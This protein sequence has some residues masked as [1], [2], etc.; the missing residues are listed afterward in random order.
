MTGSF[1]LTFPSC[2]KC[3]FG[4]KK[5][6]KRSVNQG[7]AHTV[8]GA[9]LGPVDGLSSSGGGGREWLSGGMKKPG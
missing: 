8:E 9:A 3:I 2:V 5:K 6:K 1:Y 7:C 4:K